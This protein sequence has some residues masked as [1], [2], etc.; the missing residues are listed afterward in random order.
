[1][2][3]LLWLVWLRKVSPTS[4][5][6]QHRIW[7]LHGSWQLIGWQHDGLLLMM[8]MFVHARAP[9]HMP[10]MCGHAK[11]PLHRLPVCGH[12]KEVLQMLPICGCAKLRMHM[13]AHVWATRVGLNMVAAEQQGNQGAATKHRVN[14]FII[15]H[16]CR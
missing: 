4:A 9:M 8:P 6:L 14:D 12:A 11:W 7:L 3:L 13:P 15:Y 5:P 10:P 16:I 1:M 2:C